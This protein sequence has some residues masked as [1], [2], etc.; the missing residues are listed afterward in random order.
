MESN[1]LIILN[2]D[3]PTSRSSTNIIDVAITYLTSFYN[4]K[5]DKSI[6]RSDH[7][8][9]MVNYNALNN[10]KDWQKFRDFSAEKF[11]EL[12]NEQI[13]NSTDIDISINKY[14]TMINEAIEFSTK[15]KEVNK[16]NIILPSNV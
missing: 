2:N 9:I 10:S 16:Y 7:W 14:A 1:N 11:L 8:P 12:E 3:I 15:E 13:A 4:F 6:D 5:V